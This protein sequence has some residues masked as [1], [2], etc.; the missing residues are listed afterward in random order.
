MVFNESLLFQ[1]KEEYPF[2]ENAGVLNIPKDY[3]IAMAKEY[4]LH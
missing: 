4:L 1:K 2:I 3:I